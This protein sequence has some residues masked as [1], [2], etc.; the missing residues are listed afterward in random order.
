[1][2]TEKSCQPVEN[3][4]VFSLQ[5]SSV[6]GLRELLWR[7]AKAEPTHAADER[8]VAQLIE[9]LGLQERVPS[10]EPAV[11]GRG[12]T[13]LSPEVLEGETSGRPRWMIG[14]ACAA[15]LLLVVGGIALFHN[16]P[17]ATVSAA[18]AAVAAPS[19]NTA[20]TQTSTSQPTPSQPLVSQPPTPPPSNTQPV[21]PVD[22]PKTRQELAKE[23][24]DKR[25]KAK[26]QD[27]DEDEDE[28]SAPAPAPAPVP[29]ARRGSCEYD[30]QELSG[31]LDAAERS[32]G[33]GQYNAAERQ[34][35]TV[36]GCEPGNGR[37][38][39]GLEKVRQAAH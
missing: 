6:A 18:P 9:Q 25:D 1:L 38:R 7:A 5:A 36:L 31:L 4:P 20:N 2:L 13:L 11:D 19:P 24:K 29:V 30:A 10:E 21:N 37:A 3:L 16:S 12:T 15:A 17:P 26:N 23:K 28:A 33:R 39:A 14:G 8:R 34:F 35:T 32:L 27:V 22:R